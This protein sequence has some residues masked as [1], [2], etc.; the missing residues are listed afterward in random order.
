MPSLAHMP[1]HG[2][3]AGR[4]LSRKDWT[5]ELFTLT[6]EGPV[7]PFVAG[8]FLRLGLDVAGAWVAR[9]Y[10]IASAPGAPLEIYIVAVEGGALTPALHALQPGDPVGLTPHAAGHFTLAQASSAEHL[11]M[12]A[13]GTGLA[14]FL[15]M[16][17][18]PEPWERFGRIH[19]V[20]GVRRAADLS[21][22]AEL[23]ALSEAHGGRL[24]LHPVVSRQ[25]DADALHGRIPERLA[26]LEAQAGAPLSPE[27]SQ[28]LL[29]GNPAMLDDLEALLAA[30][31]LRRPHAGQPGQVH[32]ER[33]W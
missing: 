23:R 16:L 1:D 31:G 19:L 18:T 15:S 30:R 22:A 5:P 8:Q 9:A 7:Q 26:D 3:A 17:G 13:T 27:T 12:F 2:W 6:L 32:L 28:V 21:Y 20:H 29:C 11:W 24:S 14:P 25:P 4:L 33:Y 10:S